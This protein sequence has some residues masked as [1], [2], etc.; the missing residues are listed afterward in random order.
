MFNQTEAEIQPVQISYW[1]PEFDRTLR[2]GPTLV[3]CDQAVPTALGP[4]RISINRTGLRE[5]MLAIALQRGDEELRDRVGHTLDRLSMYFA[6]PIAHLAVQDIE[7]FKPKGNVHPYVER[8]LKN[9]FIAL[10]SLAD[11]GIG[12]CQIHIKK[13]E[14]PYIAI[15]TLRLVEAYLSNRK[16]YRT[17][18]PPKTELFQHLVA[19]VWVH[20][21]EHFFQAHVDED[22]SWKQS[23]HNQ[24]MARKAEEKAT[25]ADI[26]FLTIRFAHLE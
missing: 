9:V 26:D 20:E 25:L 2:R 3:D 5:Q 12:T 19:R 4:V 15:N 7:A 1:T 21:R 18:P 22:V 16:I 23:R 11:A 24:D 10:T 6:T 17:F 8:Y 14:H 13:D